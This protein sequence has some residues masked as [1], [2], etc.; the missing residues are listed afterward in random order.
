MKQVKYE[1]NEH[2]AQK[3]ACQKESPGRKLLSDTEWGAFQCSK[4]TKCNAISPLAATRREWIS[5]SAC[6][7]SQI[8][9]SLP[10]G[11]ERGRKEQGRAGNYRR[12]E[13][14]D[15]QEGKKRERGICRKCPKI[16]RPTDRTPKQ[17]ISLVLPR[18]E[19]KKYREKERLH[20]WVE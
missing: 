19:A 18:K 13:A 8:S 10:T 11:R 7:Q 20:V 1:I 16:E 17:F 12:L 5:F 2:T 9:F 6:F 3:R 14:A 4:T 15:I